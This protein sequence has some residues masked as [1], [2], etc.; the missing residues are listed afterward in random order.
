VQRALILVRLSKRQQ[1]RNVLH[2]TLPRIKA[3]LGERHPLWLRAHYTLGLAHLQLSEFEAARALLET[4]W[5]TQHEVLGPHHPETLRTQL[6]L[7]IVL[8]F[9]D[10]DR[11]KQLISQVRDNLPKEIGRKNDLYGR[12]FLADTLLRATPAPLARHLWQLSNLLERKKSD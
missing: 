6:E 1:S 2:Q 4:V 10:S 5:T 12:T 7:G 3:R 11:S 9:T 8:K